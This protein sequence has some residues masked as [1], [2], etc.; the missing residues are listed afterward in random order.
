MANDETPDATSNV[1]KPN[2]KRSAENMNRLANDSLQSTST[3]NES[4]Y[5]GKILKNENKKQFN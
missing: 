2:R 4:H 5:D 1:Q 3:A